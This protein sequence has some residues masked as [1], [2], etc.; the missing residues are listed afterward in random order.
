[1]PFRFSTTPLASPQ[2]GNSPFSGTPTFR[3][4]TPTA[5]SP[6]KTLKVN[7]NG[8]YRW[9]GAGSSRPLKTRNH[10]HSPAFGRPSQTSERI[11]LREKD[12][13]EKKDLVTPRSEKRRRV[14]SAESCSVNGSASP[15]PPPRST[16]PAPSPTRAAEASTQGFPFPPGPPSPIGVRS[17]APSNPSPLRQAWGEGSP[18][19]TVP[20]QTKAANF[21]TELIKE[22]TPP[23][24][25]DISNPYQ[26]ASP[27]KNIAKK[28]TRTTARPAPPKQLAEPAA[29]GPKEKEYSAQAIIE[30]T[31]PKG[32]KRSR[33]PAQTEKPRSASPP[34][35]VRR[36]PRR[37]TV[38]LE[39]LDDEDDPKP[40]RS[41]PNG[42]AEADKSQVS[43][44]TIGSESVDAPQA[45]KPT[46]SAGPFG[47]PFN[48]GAL[49]ASTAPKEPSKLR[50]VYQPESSSPPTALPTAAPSIPAFTFSTPSSSLLKVA[51]EVP[52]K[53]SKPVSNVSPREAALAMS[54]ASLPTFEF[55]FPS[56]AFPKSSDVKNIEAAKALA[57]SSLPT[58][59]LSKKTETVVAQEP[60]VETKAEVI[61]FNWGATALKKPTNG[62]QWT[63]SCCMISNPAS[64]SKCMACETD[65]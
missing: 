17:T 35:G 3:S 24:R 46:T 54:S 61:G 8:P 56:A 34:S 47:R 23:K 43:A 1:M 39:E 18:S 15:P 37:E 13:L 7:P 62:G 31:L 48:V 11:V 30:A 25:P 20:R 14:N 22:V 52:S 64:A 29:E 27:V 32:S 58:F 60:I 44:E 33:P 63:C 19:E 55:S 45:V 59:D 49:K 51:V 36:S 16:A 53:S 9:Q 26:A 40:K 41:K 38:Q 12:G 10:Y 2:R 57:A 65:R 42:T 5:D 4:S 6:R 28:R 50:Y 21:M